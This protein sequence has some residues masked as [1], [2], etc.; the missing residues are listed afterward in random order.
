LDKCRAEY[1]E[2]KKE[3]EGEKRVKIYKEEELASIEVSSKELDLTT[4]D[5]K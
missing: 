5:F 3:L 4:K 1:G 2:V